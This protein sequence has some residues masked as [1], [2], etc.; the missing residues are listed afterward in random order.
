[1]GTGVKVILSP[2]SFAS[3]KTS[4]LEVTRTAAHVRALPSTGMRGGLGRTLLSAFLALTVVPLA[5]IGWYVVA[6]NRNSA[7][8]D[9]AH[10]LQLVALLKAEHLE[11]WLRDRAL[12]FGAALRVGA[13]GDQ[14]WEI[15]GGWS[16]AQGEF[17]ELDG[18]VLVRPTG[19]QV[20]GQCGVPESPNM[21]ARNSSTVNTASIG[22][23]A[24]EGVSVP[25]VFAGESETLVLCFDPDVLLERLALDRAASRGSQAYLL[26]EGALWLA[27]DSRW[28]P[29]ACTEG[30]CSLLAQSESSNS[31]YSNAA[32]MPVVGAFSPLTD[33]NL[34]ILVEQEQSEILRSGEAIVATLIGGLLSVALLTTVIAAF[35]IRQITRPVIMLTESALEM[36]E[37]NMEQN[38][39]VV[40]RDEIGILTHV[41]NQMA[42]ELKSLYDDLEAKVVART[43]LLQKANY[44]IQRRAIQLQASLEVSQAVTSIRDP[45]DLL[46]R[47]VECI[48]DRFAYVSV[49]VYLVE[50][51]GAEARLKAESPEAGAW[52]AVVHTGN[53][54]V[55]GKV[56]RKGSSQVINEIPDDD[57]PEWYR[58]ILSYV[59]TPLLI[60]RRIIGILAVCSAEYEGLQLDDVKVLEHLAN[61]VA[62]AL[63]NAR[64]YERERLA[65]QQ[66]EDNE[67][68][69]ARFLANMSHELRG[70]LNSILGFSRLMLKG[71]DGPLTEQQEGDVQRIHGNSQ[72]LLDL[73]NDILAISE[74]R[75]GALDLKF[76]TVDLHDL[77]V[78]VLPT[79]GA[80]LRGKDIQLVHE[81]SPQLPHVHGDPDRIRQV[82]VHLVTNA[83]KF[84]DRGEVGL[85]AWSDDEMAYVSVRDTGIGIDSKDRER[86]FAGFETA[87]SPEHIVDDKDDQHR[88]EGLEPTV[89]RRGAGVGL[90]VCK[91]FIELHGG[92]LWLD[93]KVGKGSA[94]T[95]SLP[96][97]RTECL[98]GQD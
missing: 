81:I 97:V 43:Q 68:F 28:V 95:F 88:N 47:V 12:L 98:D 66:L 57:S 94:F 39:P 16:R 83:A 58:R 65:A 84:T 38:V 74:I 82:L 6:Q 22:N 11:T 3:S 76:Q 32:G 53:G 55:M 23:S 25:I 17:P 33:M 48:R 49:A 27:E 56:L 92:Q 61:Q 18:V 69:K 63:Q 30:A 50:P 73:I 24:V 1:M 4:V 8:L 79:A 44:Q 86:I 70:P 36:A 93:S 45:G 14:S 42:G 89:W 96:L 52:P 87:H 90:A 60:D 35:V 77:M 78:G 46:T 91:E 71:L 62:I 34:G 37:G 80:L 5:L 20:W 10:R 72:Q 9:A 7:Q 54:T 40:S 19:S 2:K 59:G 15:D 85:H 41:F 51:G 31:W 67:A 75:A 21:P 64:A 26:R 29:L 13:S